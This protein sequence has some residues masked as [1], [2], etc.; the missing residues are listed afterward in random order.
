M[1]KYI[2]SIVALISSLFSY[3]QSNLY[4]W[5]DIMIEIETA[6][7]DVAIDQ[8]IDFYDNVDVPDDVNIELSSLTFR[9]P[10][11]PSTHVL[12]MY[13][14]STKSLAD[15]R[16][17]KTYN[18]DSW[19]AYISKMRRYTKAYSMAGKSIIS[20]GSDSEFPVGQS[21]VFNVK[22]IQGFTQAFSELIKTAKTEG[23]AELGQIIHGVEKGGNIYIWG[24]YP[25]LATAL[26]FGPKNNKEVKAFSEYFKAIENEEYIESTTRVLIK[27]W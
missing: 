23:I 1:K 17:G 19:D 3:S 6:H 7:T 18:G 10:S 13:S 25:D 11:N 4:T 16:T 8:I 15:F 22:D 21:W 20:N 12:T 24:T 9:G 26:D 2:L 14:E 27:R 5:M